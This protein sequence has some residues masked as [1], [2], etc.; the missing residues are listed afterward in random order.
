M[1]AKRIIPCL[2][3]KGGRTVKGT[4]FVNLR[5]MGD[6]VELAKRY[7]DG[8]ADELV[9]LDISATNE[10][11]STTIELVER[12]AL[13]LSIPF[14]VGGGIAS[15]DHVSRLLDCGADKISLNSSAV[16]TPD[17]IDQIAR[18]FGSQCVVAAIDTKRTAGGDEVFV[19]GGRTPTGKCTVEWAREVSERGAGEILV[20]SMDSDGVRNGFALDITARVAEVV[21]V[22]VIA[23]GG[24]GKEQHF[25][26]VFREGCADAAL[27]AGVFHEGLLT[28]GLVKEFLSNQGI[29]VRR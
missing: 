14:T 10:E 15:V 26:E 23:S 21:S 5:D 13:A 16:R 2:D 6:P 12:V 4:K 1:V 20:T 24:A 29:E 22:P 28:V 9:F 18:R 11:R 7:S 17:L 8:G 19:Q 25:L 3:I 27:A